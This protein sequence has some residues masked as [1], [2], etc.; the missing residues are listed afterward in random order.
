MSLRHLWAFIA[1]AATLLA[2]LAAFSRIVTMPNAPDY[3][4]NAARALAN[5]FNGAF[6]K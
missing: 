1:G 2:V 3:V 5:L 4:K 6:G